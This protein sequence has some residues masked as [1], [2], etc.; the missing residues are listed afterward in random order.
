MSEYGVGRELKPSKFGVNSGSARSNRA[1]RLPDQ[2][3]QVHSNTKD[4]TFGNAPSAPEV[5]HQHSHSD[6]DSGK[7]AQHHTLGVGPN[8]ASPGSHNHDGF[9]SRKIGPLEMD[10]ANPG[11]T[12][13]VWTIP[14][15]PTMG[16]IV[17]LLSKFVEFRQV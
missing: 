12:R 8:Q 14:V 17:G 2:F 3:G 10:P 7:Q 5:S 1:N 15:S 13:A 11:K 16:D 6:V 4:K 9:T